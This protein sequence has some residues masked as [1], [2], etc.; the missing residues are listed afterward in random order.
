MPSVASIS[1]S[2]IVTAIAPGALDVIGR[3]DTVAARAPLVV[4]STSA[5]RPAS[6][7]D[8]A[9]EP[10]ATAQSGVAFVQQPVVLLRDDVG[11]TVSQ[12]G[13]VGGTNPVPHDQYQ[14]LDHLRI[15]GSP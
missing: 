5:P 11:N 7:L 15:S 3:N 13:V 8:V 14:Y 9:T 10:S 1:S 12:S 4:K 6:Q 2:G